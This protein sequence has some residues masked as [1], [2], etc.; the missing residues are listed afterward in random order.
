MIFNETQSDN[1]QNSISPDSI[2]IT[3]VFTDNELDKNEISNLL[4][5]NPTNSWNANE[6]L[7]IGNAR[8]LKVA[9]SGKWYL[10]YNTLTSQIDQ[11]IIDLLNQLSKNLDNW[12]VITNKYKGHIEITA[13]QH[14]WNHNYFIN[15]TILNELASR[16]LSLIFD[17]YNINV[18]EVEQ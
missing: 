17:I 15:S 18:Y 11:G 3:L 16:N 14:L 6:I 5:C 12:K 13:Y 9:E 2:E 7:E 10:K 1:N 8:K 4:D